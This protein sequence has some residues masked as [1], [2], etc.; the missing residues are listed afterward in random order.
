MF[1]SESR[2]LPLG[3]VQVSESFYAGGRLGFSTYAARVWLRGKKPRL[4]T[5]VTR[6]LEKSCVFAIELKN[7]ILDMLVADGWLKP[8]MHL[9]LWS[10]TGTHFR[11]MR[12]LGSAAYCWPMKYKVN[13]NV[14]FLLEAHAKGCIDGH[15]GRLARV[16][17]RECPKRDILTTADLV[18]VY[19][20]D[21]ERRKLVR[22]D[23]DE[24]IYLDWLPAAAKKDVDTCVVTNTPVGIRSCHQWCFSIFDYRRK[25]YLAVDKAT[26]TGTQCRATLLPGMRCTDAR[27]CHLR[28]KKEGDVDEPIGVDEPIDEP[29]PEIGLSS[30]LNTTLTDYN[31]W[32]CD[33]NGLK[34]TLKHKQNK[35]N[36]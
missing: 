9:Q 25:N 32:R 6:V 2:T 22:P 31:G 15:G 29:L 24:E 1:P 28:F 35:I 14:G 21:Y 16:R 33:V 13:V 12:T 5:F 4:Y 7:V 34:Q 27:T 20:D 17:A 23:I 36:K 11:S 10:D 3:R 8:K 26:I 30:E 18:Q 19:E